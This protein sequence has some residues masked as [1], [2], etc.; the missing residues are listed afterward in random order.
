MSKTRSGSTD[1]LAL[2]FD[3]LTPPE[4]ALFL[5]VPEPLLIEE[6]EAG[7]IPGRKIG[8]EWR[9][10]KWALADWLQAGSRPSTAGKALSSKERMLSLAG[11]F[12]DDES[13]LPMLEE[14]YRDRKR[15]PV[16]G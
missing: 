6:A 7:R 3:V 1:Q 11:V 12:K 5:R 13:L 2:W 15:N 16:G 8:P 4:A 10:L 9:F 14:I